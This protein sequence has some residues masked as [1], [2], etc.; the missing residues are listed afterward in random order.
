MNLSRIVDVG[1]DSSFE[2]VLE[3]FRLGVLLVQKFREEDVEEARDV[4]KVE[5]ILGEGKKENH[6]PRLSR[7]R[8][9]KS[10]RT[11]FYASDQ[12][13]SDAT[14]PRSPSPT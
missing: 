7:F 13:A 3:A 6:Q 2:D 11:H 12:S 10:N 1:I 4:A 8:A 5:E 14:S 9:K